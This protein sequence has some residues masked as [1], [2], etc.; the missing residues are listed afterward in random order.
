MDSLQ[1]NS[2]VDDFKNFWENF[3]RK[4]VQWHRGTEK[5]YSR[6]TCLSQ[7]FFPIAENQ[8]QLYVV[9]L[10]KPFPNIQEALRVN[11]YIQL[12]DVKYHGLGQEDL[13]NRC[14][15]ARELL[16]QAGKQNISIEN[17]IMNMLLSG[18]IFS[19]EINNGTQD[20]R[21]SMKIGKINFSIAEKDS[22]YNLSLSDPFI[23]CERENNPHSL[24]NPLFLS[25]TNSNQFYGPKLFG[26]WNP[27]CQNIP[28][29]KR[30]DTEEYRAEVNIW[31][32][33]LNFFDQN[34]MRSCTMNGGQERA[35]VL[36]FGGR[37]YEE[38]LPA[39]SFNDP[40]LMNFLNEKNLNEGSLPIIDR[41]KLRITELIY[42]DARCNKNPSSDKQFF[43][44][45]DASQKSLR[46]FLQQED[47]PVQ[48]FILELLQNGGLF[49]VKIQTNN[50]GEF[51]AEESR[52]NIMQLI[53]KNNDAKGE[54]G[55]ELLKF[56]DRAAPKEDAHYYSLKESEEESRKRLFND[57]VNGP[58]VS[59]S[60]EITVCVNASIENYFL[61]FLLSLEKKRIMFPIS[62]GG[63]HWK[64]VPED[65][66]PNNF[67]S[68][69]KA[70]VDFS[71]FLNEKH[72]D[73]Y[74]WGISEAK[75]LLEN[76]AKII[77]NLLV[78]FYEKKNVITL[79][80]FL[81]AVY[82]KHLLQGGGALA[83]MD[84]KDFPE[85]GNNYSELTIVAIKFDPKKGG[86]YVDTNID[87]AFKR[88]TCKEEYFRDSVKVHWR[89]RGGWV[90]R[91]TFC[92]KDNKYWKTYEKVPYNI[93]GVTWEKGEFLVIPYLN[94][95]EPLLFHQIVEKEHQAADAI[96]GKDTTM[97][98]EFLN[99]LKNELTQHQKMIF[100]ISREGDHWIILEDETMGGL[101]NKNENDKKPLNK[102]ISFFLDHLTF[103]GEE[104]K[105]GYKRKKRFRAIFRQ[106][107]A[108]ILEIVCRGNQKGY[109]F[110]E[111]LKTLYSKDIKERT[112]CFF[113]METENF[114]NKKGQNSSRLTIFP[115]LFNGKNFYLKKD[116][117]M[118]TRETCESNYQ[119]EP[120]IGMHMTGLLGWT[121]RDD[122]KFLEME[123]YWK[124]YLNAKYNQHFKCWNE[125]VFLPVR[126]I[127]DNLNKKMPLEKLM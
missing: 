29:D 82:G 112:G 28:L 66:D 116:D 64:I 71:P 51:G 24:W 31:Q 106:M 124:S 127:L 80:E 123:G 70:S 55:I 6:R 47:T 107:E 45:L 38:G 41:K 110:S 43:Q 61:K 89:F 58:T 18:G 11:A 77:T 48:D 84:V 8:E 67:L 73:F 87:P 50:A 68:P 27:Y 102:G 19:I 21:S 121:P 114:I 2:A 86:F 79:S 105:G 17:I 3:Y 115:V 118:L 85:K 75:E 22:K 54:Y 4:N 46:K 34:I 72:T 60:Q 103:T 117:P 57:F 95:F 111:I 30:W 120:N 100:P 33:W 101:L 97:E 39:I 93:H 98:T 53:L 42:D 5:K 83:L 9:F 36:F 49:S 35:M 10:N 109:N 69:E 99:F 119:A 26:L 92:E 91:N 56:I 59:S 78:K 12:Q 74:P 40:N 96:K 15:T 104:G 1:K 126:A 108:F 20:A 13:I 63:D 7:F 76:G 32:A 81:K 94:N 44:A 37:P 125:E 16:N 65:F 113:L 25:V 122:E 14:K 88:K 90:P 52:M 62:F 23:F